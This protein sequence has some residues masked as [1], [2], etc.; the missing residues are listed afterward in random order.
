MNLSPLGRPVEG[1]PGAAPAGLTHSFRAANLY[2]LKDWNKKGQ[3]NCG[4]YPSNAIFEP[5][6]LNTIEREKHYRCLIHA[7][8]SSTTSRWYGS[9]SLRLMP[10]WPYWSNLR[11]LPRSLAS[12]LM[13]ANRLP[14]VN[15]S[16]TFWPWSLFSYGFGSNSSNWLGAPAMNR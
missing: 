2:S 3:R 5:Y 4:C 13:N 6:R 11:A 1:A 7:A 10:H 14:F 8:T 16:G 15:D 12:P 9:N